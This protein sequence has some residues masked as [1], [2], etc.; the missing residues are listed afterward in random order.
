MAVAVCGHSTAA[1]GLG[2]ALFVAFH[3]SILGCLI[4]AHRN[5]WFSCQ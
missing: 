5:S 3:E 2:V 1:V 4:Y